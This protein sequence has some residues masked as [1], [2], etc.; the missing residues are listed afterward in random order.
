V[1]GSDFVGDNA[2]HPSYPPLIHKLSDT[3]RWIDNVFVE[4]FWRSL[5]YEHVYLHAYADLTSARAGIGAYVRYYNGRRRHTSLGRRTPD[6]VYAGEGQGE[7][8]FA[9]HVRSS[10]VLT[11]GSTA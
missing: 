10:G 7:V 4:R 1:L 3:L 2:E 11:Q 5:K 9:R 8:P 6:A